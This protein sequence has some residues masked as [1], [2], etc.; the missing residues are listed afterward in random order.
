LSDVL[1]RQRESNPELLVPLFVHESVQFIRRKGINTLGVF[2]IR[3]KL[4]DIKELKEQLDRGV[5]IDY[6]KID[7]VHTITT[8]VKQFLR[9]LPE[10]LLTF[11]LCDAFLE[12]THLSG[13]EQI[14]RIRVNL[15]KIPRQS[16]FLL[17]YIMEVA[18]DA[19]LRAE[20]NKMTSEN[21]ATVLSPNLLWRETIDITNLAIVD[22]AKR[23][24]T[25]THLLIVNFDAFFGAESTTSTSSSS[26][27]PRVPSAA[28][29]NATTLANEDV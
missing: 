12:C 15:R 17:R 11:E 26:S 7:S 28:A 4:A 18:R 10:P 2:R 21:L 8:L 20:E 14:D 22:E 23:I 27:S 3:G 1:Q 29:E 16:Y 9:E 19:S 24:G 25:L 6:D 13:D 5:S